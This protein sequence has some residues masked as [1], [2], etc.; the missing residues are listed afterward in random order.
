[1]S[2]F[3]NEVASSVT[4]APYTVTK[5]GSDYDASAVNVTTDGFVAYMVDNETTTVR[6]G[7]SMFYTIGIV[8]P[9]YQTGDCLLYTSDAADE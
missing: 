3:E 5:A 9:P 7:V 4:V 1:M 2:I 8:L 6:P